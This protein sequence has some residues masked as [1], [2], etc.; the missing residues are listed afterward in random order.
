MKHPPLALCALLAAAPS[1]HAADYSNAV[2]TLNE[3]V[4]E[5]MREWDIGGIAVALVEDQQVVYAAGYGEA[6]R[7]SIFRVGSISK[8]FNAIGVMQQ[9]EAGKLAL[10]Q[11]LPEEVMPLNPFPEQPAV[12]LRQVLCH[13]SGLV[14]EAGVGG[15]FDAAQPGLAATVASARSSVLVTRP[16]EKTRYSNFAPS[17]AGYLVERA[18]GQGFE[19]YQREHV[20]GP[21]KM[22]DSAWTLAGVPS[23]RLAP[24]HM[25]VADGRGGWLRRNAPQFDLGTLPAGNLFSTVDDL[26]RFASAMLAGGA[27]L[28]K[29]ETL[30]E[31][32]RPQFT[33]EPSGYGLGFAVGKFREHRTISHSGAVYGYSTSLVLL[34]EEKLAVIVLGNEDVANGRIH[35]LSDQGLSLMLEAKL[36][37]KPPPPR[38]PVPAGNLEAFAGD[39][40]SQSYWA[41][42]E[43]RDGRL[44]GDISGQPTRFSRSGEMEF[45]AHSRIE[46]ATRVVFER[47]G[48][49]VATGFKMGIQHF[50]RVP[51][52]PPA[53]PGA[54]RLL[55]G[56]YG[57][58]FI[59]L[60][61]SERH[62]HLYAMTENLADY[63]LTPVNRNVCLM[64]P[65]L[66]TDEELVFLTAPDGQAH[67]VNF[68]NMIL[69]R[70]AP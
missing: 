62:G 44:A 60:V 48:Q 37:E 14:R 24:S 63:R 47:E 51:A 67:S 55:L 42:I 28:V 38:V 19:A 68:A 45:T 58:G 6:K 30:H 23:E 10:D 21:L 2:R 20:F 16:G 61:V 59:P 49:G 66:Y 17:I 15:Y 11:P 22:V 50:T 53:L 31:M 64:P 52:H 26:A 25:R 18:C 3:V 33:Q 13:R 7:D 5:E 1:P 69:S 34:P 39:Y 29:P 43:F 56:S 54:W 35:R 9:V 4:A 32:W 27:G 36:G 70:R 12:T 65:G 40:E 41:R 57:P 8:L 46:D